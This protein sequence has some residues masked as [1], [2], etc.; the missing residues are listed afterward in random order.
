M[1]TASR[2][3]APSEIDMGHNPAAE[4]VTA[5]VRVFRHGNNADHGFGVCGKLHSVIR[6]GRFIFQ[7]ITNSL[8]ADVDPAR[9]S[10][11]NAIVGSNGTQSP[12]CLQVGEKNHPAYRVGGC[13]YAPS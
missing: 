2:D 12:R 9:T 11:L 1:G 6:I 10:R 13:E 8:C 4:D 7:G 5:W 3:D